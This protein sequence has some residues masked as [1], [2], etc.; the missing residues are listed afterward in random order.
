MIQFDK[1]QNRYRY[2][3]KHGV[4]IHEG[5]KIRRASGQV[6]MV[7]EWENIYGERGLGTDA[8]NPV[9]IENGRAVP[10]EF[11]I[12]NLDGVDCSTCEVVRE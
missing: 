1:K 3:D 7:Y 12:Y 6:E 4:E 5:D 9:W 2:F 8:T 11:G 10:C